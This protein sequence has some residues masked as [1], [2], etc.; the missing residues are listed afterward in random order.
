[1]R[2]G[3]SQDFSTGTHNFLNPYPHPPTCPC[4]SPF[5]ILKF[6]VAHQSLLTHKLRHRKRLDF[7]Y[8]FLT[9]SGMHVHSVRTGSYAP[10]RLSVI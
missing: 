1:M 2:Q 8:P 3:R 9:F 10:V 7:F 4:T 5:K 6:F